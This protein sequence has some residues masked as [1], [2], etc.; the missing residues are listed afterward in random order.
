MFEKEE[1]ENLSNLL[2]E[3]YNKFS[4][5]EESVIKS[6]KYNLTIAE[7]HAIEVLGQVDEI[8]MKQL[9]QKLGVST[10]SVTAVIDRLEKKGFVVRVTPEKDRRMFLIKLTDKGLEV[11][12]EHH[13]DHLKLAE[14]IFSKIKKEDMKKFKEILNLIINFF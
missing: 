9:A 6:S 11:Y 4:S 2:T 1:L 12:N 7:T 13:K 8:N 10:P 5:W 14:R 3:L